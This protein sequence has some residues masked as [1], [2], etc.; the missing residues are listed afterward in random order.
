MPRS[1]KTKTGVEKFFDEQTKVRSFAKNYA[2]ARGVDAIDKVVRALDAARERAD[3][4][5]ASGHGC[6]VSVRCAG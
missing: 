4:R 1:T 6:P 5:Y 2:D 3:E